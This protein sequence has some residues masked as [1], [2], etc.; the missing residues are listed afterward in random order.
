MIT[1]L[2]THFSKH[3]LCQA[4]YTME[5]PSNPLFQ[6]HS[7]SS[8]I[9][10]A[11][12]LNPLFQRYSVSSWIPNAE[13]QNPLFQR[14]CDG[15]S[16]KPTFPDTYCFKLNPPMQNPSNPLFQRHSVSSWI[17]NGEPWGIIGAEFIARLCLS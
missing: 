6:R 10:N 12:H 17:P 5:N 4:G 14:H 9:P 15:K 11:E 13:P 16:L 7:V 3:I 1:A 8:W 2:I